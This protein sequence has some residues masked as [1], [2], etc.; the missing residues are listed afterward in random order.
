MAKE[1]RTATF[2]YP[3]HELAPEEFLHFV[4]T[5]EFG[6]DWKRL[7]LSVETDLWALQTLIMSAP[8]ASPVIKGTGG[9]RKIRFAPEGWNCGKSGAVRVCYAYFKEHWTVLLVMAYGKGRKETLSAA[10]KAGIKEYLSIIQN[11]LDS[12]NY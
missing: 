9:L 4:E 8:E 3:R 1:R 7:G 2:V 11:Y 6:D 12:H 5:D 10:E